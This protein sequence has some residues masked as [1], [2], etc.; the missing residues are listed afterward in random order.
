MA[1]HDN[2]LVAYMP[3]LLDFALARDQRWYRIPVKNADRWVGRRWPPVWL[4]WYFPKAFGAERYTIT[5]FAHVEAIRVATRVELFPDAPGHPRAMEAYY[6][7]RLGPLQRR[8]TPIIARRLRRVTFI[9]TTWRKFMAAEEINDL[10]D[11]SLLE[12]ALWA[13]LKLRGVSADRQFHLKIKSHNYFLDFAITC[14]KGPLAVETDGDRWHTDPKRILLDNRR[15]NALETA[16]WSLLR[17]STRAINEQ[18][19]D[20]CLPTIAEK[21]KELDGL[22]EGGLIGRQLTLRPDQPRQLGLFESTHLL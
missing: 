4:A 7:L 22:D 11:D 16:G 2:L 3:N 1:D 21:I 8:A 18:M 17:F 14:H 9:P 5:T 13:Q 15:D 19:A 20:Y 12:D 6:Q 10:F